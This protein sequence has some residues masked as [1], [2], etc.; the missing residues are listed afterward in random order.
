[1]CRS[2]LCSCRHPHWEKTQAAPGRDK[3]IY[4]AAIPFGKRI[5]MP[6]AGAKVCTLPP[7]PAGKDFRPTRGGKLIQY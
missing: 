4:P 5:R 6:R 1:M 7:S 2:F 3:N